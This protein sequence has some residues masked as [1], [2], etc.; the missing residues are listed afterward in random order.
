MVRSDNATRSAH[1]HHVG[2]VDGTVTAIP[3]GYRITGAATITS[4][5]AAAPFSGS[6]VVVE[7][8]GNTAVTLAKIALTFQGA[9]VAHF[10]DQPI[11]GVVRMP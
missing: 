7:V 5:G 10:G 2:L 6:P 4:N 8:T 3:N 11:E 1:T 9:A